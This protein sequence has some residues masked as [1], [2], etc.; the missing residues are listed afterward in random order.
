[1]FL[2]LVHNGL[3]DEAYGDLTL[4]TFKI[5]QSQN[6]AFAFIFS[7]KKSN[8]RFGA[9]PRSYEPTK[10]SRLTYALLAIVGVVFILLIYS[11]SPFVRAEFLLFQSD[12]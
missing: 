3:L 10:I 2:L 12:C 6:V 1:M 11:L 7:I 8:Q 4:Q 9:A 5:K